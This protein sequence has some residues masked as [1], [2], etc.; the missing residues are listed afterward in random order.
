MA[1]FFQL[2]SHYPCELHAESL[3]EGF[4]PQEVITLHCKDN[5]DNEHEVYEYVG[6]NK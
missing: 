3:L 6:Q 1:F 2:L 4:T 5:D